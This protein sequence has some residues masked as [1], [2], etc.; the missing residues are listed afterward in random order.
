MYNIKIITVSKIKEKW[1][2]IAIEDYQKRLSNI[3]LFN[4]LLTKN[5]SQ[6]IKHCKKENFFICLDIKGEKFSSE[7]LSETL[8]K[9]LEKNKLNLTFVIGGAEGLP[10][11]I[12]NRANIS[13]SFSDLT[14]THQ[15]SRLILL[16]QIYRSFE[17]AKGSKYHK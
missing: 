9:L 2:E 7:K 13:I 5:D 12:K 6:L 4:W 8:L 11:E 10:A 1:L 3:V 14:F 17:I 15:I 16:E